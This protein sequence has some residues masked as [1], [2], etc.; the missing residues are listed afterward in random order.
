MTVWRTRS[1]A[2]TREV[3]AELLVRLA[4][5]GI[6]C[7]HGELGTGKTTLTQGLAEAMGIDPSEVQS[8]SYT[9]IREHTGREGRLIHID[10]YRLEAPQVEALGI[11]EVLDSPAVK[12]IE[13]PERLPFALDDALH[14]ELSRLADG[15]RKIRQLK[16][17]KVQAANRVQGT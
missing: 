10:L 9:I 1:E 15:S 5:A 17:P 6:L 14:L 16:G 2:E 13:W 12:A 7:L 3:G 11:D 4:P 8:P